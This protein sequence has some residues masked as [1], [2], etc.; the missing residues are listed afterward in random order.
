M[1]FLKAEIHAKVPE[2][3]F[4]LLLLF[5]SYHGDKNTIYVF[6]T[7]TFGKN[8][9]SHVGLGLVYFASKTIPSI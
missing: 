7:R 2:M 9:E 1:E 6:R 5:M 8:I 3:L 4:M